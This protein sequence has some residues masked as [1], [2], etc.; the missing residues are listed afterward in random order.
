MEKLIITYEE[1]P[2]QIKSLIKSI[3]DELFYGKI[4]VEKI[5]DSINT[6]TNLI[7]L[8]IE[9]DGKNNIEKIQKSIYEISIG[10]FNTQNRNK[11]STSLKE[12][13]KNNIDI[14]NASPKSIVEELEKIVIHIKDL[15]IKINDELILD[16]LNLIPELNYLLEKIT[17][18]YKEYIIKEKYYQ[19]THNSD[20]IKLIDMY[21]SINKI[22]I[23]VES[24]YTEDIVK[25]ILNESFKYKILPADELKEIA[26]K[27]QNG[28]REA[29]EKLFLHNMRLVINMAKRYI[30]RGLSFE[31]LIQEGNMGLI[32]AIENFDPYK[33]YY[34]STYAT[35]WIR[36]GITRSIADKSRNIRIPV[37]MYD[38]I[39]KFNTSVAELAD[40]KGRQPTTQEISEYLGIDEEKVIEF[41][42]IAEDTVSIHTKVGD[43]EDSE[44]LHFIPE[45]DKDSLEEE[46]IKQLISE[47][48][49]NYIDMIKLT[50]RE[51]TV[52][53]YRFELD[54]H[55]FM[56]LEELGDM[57]DVTRERIRQI[58]A[59]ALRKI[60]ESQN[61]KKLCELTNDPERAYQII[62][63][64]RK[65]KSFR[66]TNP[67]DAD[68]SY[69]KSI[70]NIVDEYIPEEKTKKKRKKEQKPKIEKNINSKEEERLKA[71]WTPI[72]LCILFKKSIEELNQITSYFT[73]DEKLLLHKY[74]DTFY[75]PI[76]IINEDT[77]EIRNNRTTIIRLIRNIINSEEIKKSSKKYTNPESLSYILAKTNEEIRILIND[78]NP[79][80]KNL[81][82][83][84]Y[85]SNYYPINPQ[86]MNKTN[87][88]Y[89][90]NKIIT[91]LKSLINEERKEPKQ[92]K[93]KSIPE[94]LG[95]DLET[96]KLIVG[97]LSS[98]YKNYIEKYYDINLRRNNLTFD[99]NDICLRNN[100]MQ[101]CHHILKLPLL[102]EKRSL[103]EITGYTKEELDEIFVNVDSK[104]KD[105][106]N[107]FFD[108]NYESRKVL[109]FE[110]DEIKLKRIYEN[111]VNF[112]N[113]EKKTNYKT[114]TAKTLYELLGIDLENAKQLL[115]KLP[116]NYK[117]LISKYYN[118]TDLTR[119]EVPYIRAES[120]QLYNT[121]KY[122]RD[123]YINKKQEKKRRLK[124]FAERCNLPVSKLNE[125]I[126][127]LTPEERVLINKYYN[128]NYERN[129]IPFKD[130]EGIKTNNIVTRIKNLV[131]KQER[132][133]ANS[134]NQVIE[135]TTNETPKMDCNP[136]FNIPVNVENNILL[137]N[138][139]NIEI[140]II[141]LKLGVGYNTEVVASLL[142]INPQIV[143]DVTRR[144]LT[145]YQ[146]EF[147]RLFEE[148]I[149][150]IVNDEYSLT[151]KK[152]ENN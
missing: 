143:R 112:Y 113:S 136:S 44:L 134:S 47:G 90:R 116:D 62:L 38:K 76:E 89:N 48:V 32:K 35:W 39:K 82:T 29:Y 36:Q 52:L 11:I 109:I 94:L 142:N 104:I 9:F 101:R 19:I 98:K 150:S 105:I 111:I 120:C 41:Y 22:D 58:E 78:L 64:Y 57:F 69:N 140:V 103:L 97:S 106:I 122:I 95:V 133:K 144:Y 2:E 72:S 40:K 7:K 51:K 118:L 137:S 117:S 138:F 130:D 84:F 12:Y 45:T 115:L 4:R 85:D 79:E 63:E 10:L 77:T 16:L 128:E 37:H 53:M 42:R 145:L 88:I 15:G 25:Q 80:I 26:I 83:I 131:R 56:T 43:K 28:S 123:N 127:L 148:R 86:N 61:V 135:I 96:A 13:I 100:V 149:E 126:K 91:A 152:E 50:E 23:S 27:Y 6:D 71:K 30:G 49:L 59:K 68:Y 99:N 102:V 31:D 73:D 129:N 124:S 20:T 46:T 121:I 108:E 139:N 119:K 92:L 81:V 125:I 67:L 14:E 5:I 141:S 132:L 114:K 147:N 66:I 65:A 34:F 1:L 151:R 3:K 54:N 21:V 55:P 93:R 110:R 107:K 60:F 146:S 87:I 75:S 17:T 33:G 8:I 18:F 74:Y 70:I 24:I